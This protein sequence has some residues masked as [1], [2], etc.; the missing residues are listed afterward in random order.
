MTG[1]MGNVGALLI[2]LLGAIVLE[3]IVAWAGSILHSVPSAGESRYAV[4]T[5]RDDQDKPMTTNILMNMLIPNV[6]MVFVYMWASFYSLEYILDNIMWFV[7][8][9]FAYRFVL[10][11]IILRR[12]ELF[13]VGYE[14]VVAGVAIVIAYILKT[15]FF[16]NERNI[17][18]PVSELTNELWIAI[19]LVLYKFAQLVVDKWV[20]Q[21]TV[22]KESMIVQYIA[23]K[24]RAFYGK[25]GHLVEITVENRYTCILMYAIMIF[26]DYNRGPFLRTL[27]RIKFIITGKGTLGIMQVQADKLITDEESVVLAYE[28]LSREIVCDEICVYDEGQI[29]DYAWQYNNDTDY[30]KSVSYIFLRL[31]DFLDETPRFRQAF[32]LREERPEEAEDAV[33]EEVAVDMEQQEAAQELRPLVTVDDLA[34]LT[35]LGRKEILKKM[36]KHRAVILLFEEEAME[37][38]KEEKSFSGNKG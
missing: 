21:R 4:F 29:N 15:Y 17:F 5:F 12:K 31:Y 33:P 22:T 26:E 18:I 38:L 32:H 8:F 9:Y 16:V 34:L 23:K 37:I 3:H 7:I 6:A 19:F 35:G 14:C 10:V 27:E 11:C 2:L 28:K 30:A 36:R 1:S 20:T 13:R 25:Y 24:F